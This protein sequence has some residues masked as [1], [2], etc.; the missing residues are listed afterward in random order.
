MLKS[1]RIDQLLCRRSRNQENENRLL[2]KRRGRER[3]RFALNPLVS[4][5]PGGPSRFDGCELNAIDAMGNAA[6]HPGEP[7]HQNPFIR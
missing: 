5:P 6:I 7:M 2:A 1:D 3:I 4:I